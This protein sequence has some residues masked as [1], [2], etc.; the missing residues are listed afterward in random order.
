M[1]NHE[2]HNQK[3]FC[4]SKRSMSIISAALVL[5]LF[6]TFMTGYVWGK[7]VA[8]EDILKAVEQKT[9][10]DQISGSIYAL[11]SHDFE[12]KKEDLSDS[13]VVVVSAAVEEVNQRPLDRNALDNDLVAQ[14]I[15]QKENSVALNALPESET[16]KQ[17]SE[18]KYYAPLIGFGSKKA[19]DKFVALLKDNPLRVAIKERTS[20]GLYGKKKVWYQ[21]VTQQY[22]D[23]EELE[24]LV[25]H[26]VKKEH[27]SGVV[28]VAC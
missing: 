24:N 28:V 7:R 23:K 1:N 9:F 22:T 21:V 8:L 10:A 16:A 12:V 20:T 19:A 4:T 26:V 14:D 5:I 6:L 18:N 11:S 2:N 15:S 13:D 17:L 27:L 25:A 3:F